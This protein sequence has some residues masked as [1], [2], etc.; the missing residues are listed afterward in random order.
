MVCIS[1]AEKSDIGFFK[2]R[3]TGQREGSG[4]I[5]KQE[6]MQTENLGEPLRQMRDYYDSGATR[7]YAFRRQ[8]LLALRQA[9]LS[10]EQQISIALHSDLGKSPEE[11]YGTETGLLL[12]E[13]STALK[14]L[15]DWMHPVT[16]A[17]NLVNLPS[18]SKIFRDP[19][20]VVLIIAPWNY[21][22]QLALIPLVGAIAAG[23][24]AVVKPSEL[25]PA[26][27]AL[28]EKIISSI[29]APQYVRVLTGEGAVLV[30]ALMQSF[31][32]DHVFYT[33]SIAVGKAVYK[34]A[35]P[36]LV[37]V[38]LELGGKSPVVIEADANLAVAA[39]R[40]ALGK[41]LNCG[42]TC[43]AP[44]YL[45]VHET[46]KDR[47]L[48]MLQDTIRQ[49]FGEDPAASYSY[50]KIINEKQFDRLLGY[51]SMGRVVFG[52]GYDR[53]RRYFAPT[54]IDQVALDS[55]LMTEEIFGPLLPVF[56][57]SRTDEALDLIRRNPNPLAFYLF[58]ASRQTEKQWIEALAFG[59]GC[60]N[61]TSWHFANDH[62]PFGGIAYSGTGAYHGKY[63]FD[64]F[65]HA[66]PVMKT[67]TWIDPSIRY[68]P[69]E[70]KLKWF[71]RLIK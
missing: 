6:S 55:P 4:I 54:L 2:T 59:G 28:M 58:T 48:N 21:P 38:T 17:T 36:E 42:Q 8:Q 41:F 12:A 5:L 14:H 67:P 31:R 34:L 65:S 19:L 69:F 7:S 60:V 57:F 16:V 66:K 49:F 22:F 68:P 40:I 20:G 30:P 18:R 37:P 32:F 61:N 25:S 29:Y 15:R 47:F 35:A 64:L 52:G 27:S 39:R 62:L 33:G 24:C 44:D 9:V 71:R 1:P 56:G 3:R 50:G 53:T 51:L 11:V 45:L 70:G 23:N 43:I 63:T 13:I 46:V 26:T 10:S